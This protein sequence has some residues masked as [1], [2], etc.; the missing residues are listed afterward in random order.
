M[1]NMSRKLVKQINEN[2]WEHAK[3]IMDKQPY[4]DKI[5]VAV[6]YGINNNTFFSLQ[7]INGQYIKVTSTENVH[8][9]N[10]I[11]LAQKTN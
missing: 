3:Q 6:D 11:Q 10:P 9:F 1:N 2:H 8:N 7:K 4:L 5:I